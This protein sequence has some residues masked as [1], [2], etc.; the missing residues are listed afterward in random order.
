MEPHRSTGGL[1]FD[2]SQKRGWMDW[3]GKQMLGNEEERVVHW[4]MWG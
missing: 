4:G 1:Q 3:G 2:K